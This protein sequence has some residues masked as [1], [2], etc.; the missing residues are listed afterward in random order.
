MP[1]NFRLSAKSSFIGYENA[2][3]AHERRLD[4]NSLRLRRRPAHVSLATKSWASAVLANAWL[5]AETAAGM[6]G[7]RLAGGGGAGERLA[8]R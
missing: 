5:R 2:W 4:I 8:A 3:R 6:E 7:Q 1:A